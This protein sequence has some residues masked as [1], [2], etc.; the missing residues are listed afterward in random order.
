MVYL[1][2]VFFFRCQDNP[3]VCVGTAAFRRAHGHHGAVWS[4][5]VHS[6]QHTYWIQVS[7]FLQP[8]LTKVVDDL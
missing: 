7:T 1:T 2:K 4:R 3:Q 6:T 5:Q 8:N